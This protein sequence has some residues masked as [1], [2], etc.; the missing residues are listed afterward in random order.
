MSTAFTY[1]QKYA[2]YKNIDNLEGRMVEA[3]VNRPFT[4]DDVIA[5]LFPAHIIDVCR[6]AYGKVHSPTVAIIYTFPVDGNLVAILDVYAHNIAL[7]DTKCIVIS[8]EAG[9]L[10]RALQQTREIVQQ[11]GLV[12]DLVEW[13]NEHATPGAVRYYAPAL[14]SLLPPDNTPLFE[15]S[16]ERYREPHRLSEKLPILRSVAAIVAQALL[17]PEP[18]EKREIK[19][20]YWLSKDLTSQTFLL[21]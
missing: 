1:D 3:M 16:G 13:M 4:Y 11:F 9:P 19:I 17:L 6:A 21:V 8:D 14:L 12:R 10:K 5:W 7:P 15:A 2:I 20:T 18:I